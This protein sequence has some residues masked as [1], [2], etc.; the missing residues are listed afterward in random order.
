MIGYKLGRELYNKYLKEVEDGIIILPNK[1]ISISFVKGFISNYKGNFL[2][3]FD[4]RGDEK[5]VMKFIKSIY[6]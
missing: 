6:Y 5:V 1:N 3:R 4:I 2:E